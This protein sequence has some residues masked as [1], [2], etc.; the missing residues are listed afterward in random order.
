MRVIR[1]TVFMAPDGQEF[2]K[3][4]TCVKHEQIIDIVGFLYEDPTIDWRDCDA[5]RVVERLLEGYI[6]VPRKDKT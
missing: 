4:E 5:N 3:R 1:K 6:V 2:D